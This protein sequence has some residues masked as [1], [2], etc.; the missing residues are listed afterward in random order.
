MVISFAD[1][2]DLTGS[3]KGAKGFEDIGS[4]SA[5]L[6]DESTGYAKCEFETSLELVYQ[7]Q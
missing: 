1:K 7:V 6:V 4:E 2:L 3:S 5:Q